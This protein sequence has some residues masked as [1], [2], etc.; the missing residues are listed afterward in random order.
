MS[1][2]P[3]RRCERL[4]IGRRR[5]EVEAVD[6]VHGLVVSRQIERPEIPARILEDDVLEQIA[7]DRERRRA[8]GRTAPRQLAAR[9]Q[10]GKDLG[11]GRSGS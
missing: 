2:L 8:A 6:P 7:A 10:P 3:P 5:A 1:S 4:E 11:A 9:L